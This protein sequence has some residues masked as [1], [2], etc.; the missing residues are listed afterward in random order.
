MASAAPLPALAA[1]L[2]LVA[3]LAVFA[4]SAGPEPSR[5]E[6]R[7]Y[8]EREREECE[9]R[10]AGPSG[11]L[12]WLSDILFAE[13]RYMR[14][15]DAA[16]AA[17]QRDLVRVKVERGE[18]PPEALDQPLPSAAEQQQPSLLGRVW[19]ELFAETRYWRERDAAIAAR[20]ADLRRV[21]LERG[22]P[23]VEEA[24]TQLPEVPAVLQAAPKARPAAAA[25]WAVSASAQEVPSS[26][27][28]LYDILFA[29]VNYMQLRDQAMAARDRDLVRV[30]VERGELPAEALHDERLASPTAAVPTEGGGLWDLL[31]PERR[32]MALRRRTL[33]ARHRDLVRTKIERGELPPDA[34]DNLAEPEEPAAGPGPLTRLRDAIFSEG[35]LMEL[36][37]RAMAQRQ[38]DLVRVKVERGEL[39]AE[40][41][42][43]LDELDEPTAAPQR[44]LIGRIWDELFAESR[45][46]AERN[47]AIAA[48][49]EDLRRHKEALARGDP[50]PA[51]DEAKDAASDGDGGAPAATAD[52]PD[53][54]VTVE[55]DD[56]DDDDDDDGDDDDDDNDDDDE[57]GDQ[58]EADDADVEADE[59]E[60]GP[61]DADER[62]ESVPGN[63][64]HPQ[65]TPA[66]QDT[67]AEQEDTQAEQ[68]TQAEGEG[69]RAAQEDEVAD[70]GS[71]V[72]IDRDQPGVPA[73]DQ[74]DDGH[75]ETVDDDDDEADDDS[76]ADEYQ[77]QKTDATDRKDDESH[78]K[79]HVD[80]DAEEDDEDDDEEEDE[81]EDEDSAEN[82]PEPTVAATEPVEPPERAARAQQP[83]PTPEREQRK[84][85][86][87]PATRQQPPPSPPPAPST[88]P[89]VAAPA[90]APAPAPAPAPTAAPAPPPTAAPAPPPVAAPAPTVP[91]PAPA[92]VPSASPAPAP[93]ASP[94]ARP[95]HEVEQLLG[96]HAP[97]SRPVEDATN[98]ALRELKRA[99]D[100]AIKPLEDTYKYNSVSARTLADAEIFAKPV[101]LF[102]GQL[103]S[104]KSTMI[105]YL[106]GTDATRTTA[107]PGSGQFRI[108]TYGDQDERQ[109]G[110]QVTAHWE[111]SGL[112]KFGE[113]FLERLS[114][115]QLKNRLLEKVNV[116]DVPGIMEGRQYGRIYPFNDV[117]Q[118]F[119]DR[120]DIIFVVFDPHH[121][122]IGVEME[123]LLDQLKGRE[124][125]VRII[126]NKADQLPAE[127]LL[128]VQGGLIWSLSP[129]IGS[130]TP[131]PIYSG[132]FI[133]QPYRAGAPAELFRSQEDAILRDIADSMSRRV[134][135]RIALARRHAVRVRNHAR[136][137]DCYV[138]TFLN[139][140]TFLSNKKKLAD[141]VVSNPHKYHIYEG[142]SRVTNISRYDLPD[143]EVYE[144]FFTLHPLYDFPTL[145]S[146]CT[147]FKG[148]PLDKLD[149]A[150]SYDL[151]ELLGKYRK[152]VE[153]GTAAGRRG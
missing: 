52:A 86:P 116:V 76:D 132:S 71:E 40:A 18:L 153:R 64:A 119:I 120:A 45:Y 134:D 139:Q 20:E 131:P 111:F 96:L 32:Q 136:M 88:P 26:G 78:D 75:D 16:I 44:S 9:T 80:T 25:T 39:P 67:Q 41:L 66:E 94:T 21:K 124:N 90:A 11:P 43:R 24:P 35:R 37:R 130:A 2:L 74:D 4:A 145:A 109:D 150:I 121:L 92:P 141:D 104:G 48:R 73:G 152:M 138:T 113:A 137:V 135:N 93:T 68:D 103:N 56:D 15:R 13:S 123:S 10:A 14:Q 98:Y 87:A 148:C 91:A 85:A 23:V 58:D 100:T 143:P 128:T 3:S 29:E 149:V 118:W 63:T 97:F 57:V 108:L 36:R 151:P 101:I 17:R 7:P 33:A 102:L 83:P 117:C 82:E 8:I 6:C 51:V 140:Q 95:R 38:R 70:A 46:L 77:E 55:T 42:E 54:D 50:P 142:I 110:A 27:S 28:W 30:K 69:A 105:N 144:D 84:S 89:P 34:L 60:E 31:F 106:L 59:D 129:L 125:Q 19:G 99:A 53:T 47:A 72:N 112:L 115:R 61:G 79:D 81:D 126:L 107:M 122:D 49:Q 5:E 1:A 146:T 133:S 114:G 22:E 127:Q 147:Y 62:E 12:N 65:D